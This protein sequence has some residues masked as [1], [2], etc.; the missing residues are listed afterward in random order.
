MATDVNFVILVTCENPPA[1]DLV[2][3]RDPAARAPSPYLRQLS[4]K[5]TIPSH[6]IHLM[7]C[8]GQGEVYIWMWGVC[9]ISLCTP[10]HI[11]K[12]EVGAYAN[13]SRGWIEH[14]TW[15]SVAY[16]ITTRNDCLLSMSICFGSLQVNMLHIAACCRWIWCG[17][18]SLLEWVE[19]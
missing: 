3:G 17:V 12:R 14:A 18:P 9:V 11:G 4:S 1:E 10:L 7:D 15:D 8:I 5:M 6:C 19:E 16:R 2:P 13:M